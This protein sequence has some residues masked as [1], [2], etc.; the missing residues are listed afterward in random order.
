MQCAVDKVNKAFYL[1]AAKL[2]KAAGLPGTAR[3]HKENAENWKK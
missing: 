2:A 1:K 3:M